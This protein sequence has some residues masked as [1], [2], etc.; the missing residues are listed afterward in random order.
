M[1][2][3]NAYAGT[4]ELNITV[5]G[6]ATFTDD[7]QMTLFT[8]EAL[9]STILS[10]L[11]LNRDFR[12]FQVEDILPGLHQSYLR[13][14]ATQREESQSILFHQ[15]KDRGMLVNEE[16]LHHRRGPG[17]TCRVSLKSGAVGTPYNNINNS[18]G[19]ISLCTGSLVIVV[20]VFD[21]YF[22]CSFKSKDKRKC[23]WLVIEMSPGYLK[24]NSL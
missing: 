9:L 15:V 1:S 23:Q 10:F 2:N 5:D 17:Q 22:N 11:A 18:K 20:Y 16:G 12:T 13:W 24:H 21:I 8:A 14:L 7:T 19:I 3:V 6:K 4:R